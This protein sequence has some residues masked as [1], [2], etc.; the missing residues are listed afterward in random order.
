MYKSN[1]WCN[2]AFHINPSK[3]TVGDLNVPC[4]SEALLMNNEDIHYIISTS[5]CPQK[6]VIIGATSV[7]GEWSHHIVFVMIKNVL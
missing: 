6:I 7:N 4:Y 3:T 1:A 2:L 5:F